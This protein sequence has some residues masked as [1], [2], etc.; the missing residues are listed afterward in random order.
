MNIYW[1]IFFIVIF[2]WVGMEAWLTLRKRS[3]TGRDKSLWLIWTLNLFAILIGNILRTW[4]FAHI[5][6]NSDL[7]A[8]LGTVI[9]LAGLT[10]RIWAIRKLGKF[11]E[12]V[13]IIKQDQPIIK[14]G[15]YK[16]IRHP[17]YAG[18]WLS[19]IGCGIALGNWIGLLLIMILVFIG[20]YYRIKQ[21]EK[22]LV[23][24]FGDEYRSYI[25]TTKKLIPFVY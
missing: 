10:F 15:P 11:F 24:G 8:V 14:T 3:A 6:L 22:F 9:I 7:L 25:R 23:V 16:Y 2:F 18:G 4:S 12:P 13:V 20:F 1:I 21:E 17:A 19:F 5:S